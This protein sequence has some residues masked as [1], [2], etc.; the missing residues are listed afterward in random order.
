MASSDN[1]AAEVGE[2]RTYAYTG[3]DQFTVD[4]WYEAV[5]QGR[6]FV[7]NGPMLMLT[8]EGAMPGDEIHVGRTAKV[9]IRARAWAPEAIGTPKILEVVSHGQVIHSVEPQS[10][11]QEKLEVELEWPVTHS[12]WIA[13]RTTSVNGAL[14]HTS[15]VYAL[16]GGESFANRD[17][18]AHVVTKRLK[19]LASDWA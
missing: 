14:A 1:P 17:T 7:A 12:R 8:V 11:R 18:A 16:V 4:N 5:K 15:P 13:A 6:T 19:A 10:P 3:S 2:A 9:T